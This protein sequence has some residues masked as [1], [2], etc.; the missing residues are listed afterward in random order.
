MG[1][2]YDFQSVFSCFLSILVINLVVELDLKEKKTGYLEMNFSER[3]ERWKSFLSLV[4]K[5]KYFP[6]FVEYIKNFMKLFCILGFY[7]VSEN[8]VCQESES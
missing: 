3:V 6:H 4:F 7:P 2:N 1:P 5:S 8:I